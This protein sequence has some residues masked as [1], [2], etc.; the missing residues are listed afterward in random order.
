MSKSKSKSK[1]K[2]TLQVP[3]AVGDIQV[4]TPPAD[5]IE[6]LRSEVARL[7]KQLEYERVRADAYDEMINVAE[8]K[9]KIPVRKTKLA[10]NGNEPA[11]KGRGRLS[12]ARSL[13]AVWREQAGILQA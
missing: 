10:P 4:N 12:R 2:S 6:S 7:Q 3:Q 9:F 5:D 8:A 13:Q 11:C 1:S